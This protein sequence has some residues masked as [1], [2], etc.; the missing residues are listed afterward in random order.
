MLEMIRKPFDTRPLRQDLHCPPKKQLA[1][2]L[3]SSATGAPCLWLSSPATQ[4]RYALRS[5]SSLDEKCFIQIFKRPTRSRS[6]RRVKE[7]ILWCWKRG[8]IFKNQ[9]ICS[10]VSSRPPRVNGGMSCCK[11]GHCDWTQFL[12]RGLGSQSQN[13]IEED[14]K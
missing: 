13:Q 3:C 4:P 1:K 14:E 2:I 8:Q 5:T 7:T 6:R 12:Q 11:P 9:G 10:L